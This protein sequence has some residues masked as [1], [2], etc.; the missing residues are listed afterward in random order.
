MANLGVRYVSTADICAIY[1]GLERLS[2]H[3]PTE[4]VPTNHP[5]RNEQILSQ[6]LVGSPSLT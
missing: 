5:P 4:A 6:L 2:H 1:Q 3:T